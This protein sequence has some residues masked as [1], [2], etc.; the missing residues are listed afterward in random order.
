MGSKSRALSTAV[1]LKKTRRTTADKNG[2]ITIQAEYPLYVHTEL[3][4]HRRFARNASS[5]RA[6]STQRYVDMGFYVPPVF[7]KSSKGMQAGDDP[8]E[9]QWLSSSIFYI[10]YMFCVF[11][12]YMLE[13]LGVAKEQRNRLIPP[14]KIVRCIITGTEGSWKAFL[15]LRNTKGADKAMR[16][17]AVA[18]QEAIEA[19]EWTY[20]SLHTPYPMEDEQTVIANVARVSYNRTSGKDDA[21]LYESLKADGHMSPFEHVAYWCYKPKLS[22]YSCVAEEDIDHGYGWEQLRSRVELAK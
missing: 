18:C 13:R 22:C 19:S 12:V 9:H 17:F 21:A 14:V 8:I 10:T 4:T 1:V 2:L 6:M 20:S 11:M 5:A 7:Y 15:K 3:L 16:Q